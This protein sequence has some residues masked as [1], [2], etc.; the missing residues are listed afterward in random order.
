MRVIAI[1]CCL[2][3]CYRVEFQSRYGELLSSHL[4]SSRFW[5]EK[6]RVEDKAFRHE[7]G[8]IDGTSFHK[9]TF[10]GVKLIYNGT[11]FYDVR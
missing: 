11:G 2:T 1:G 6:K 4:V 5:S 3:H 7:S 9:C 10:E 8:V